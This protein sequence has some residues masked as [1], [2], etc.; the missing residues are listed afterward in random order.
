M[1]S[2]SSLLKALLL[3][4]VAASIVCQVSSDVQKTSLHIYLLLLL[5]PNKLPVVKSGMLRRAP[6]VA[7]VSVPNKRQRII[8]T[9]RQ[10]SHRINKL[11][12][13]NDTKSRACPQCVGEK[14]PHRQRVDR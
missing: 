6:A 7:K 11:H 10:P 8:A 12:V 13:I 1:S 9:C 2:L 4:L 5:F 14:H 3:V